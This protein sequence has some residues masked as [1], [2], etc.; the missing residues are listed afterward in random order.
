M[1]L[2]DKQ[3][4]EQQEKL[5]DPK[6]KKELIEIEDELIRKNRQNQIDRV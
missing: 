5:N 4:Q 3:Y 2:T 6:I 1:D